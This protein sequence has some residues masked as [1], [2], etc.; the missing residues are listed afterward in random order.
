[1]LGACGKGR[2]VTAQALQHDPYLLLSTILLAGRS[3]DILHHPLSGG[4]RIFLF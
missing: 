4:F 1:M 3:A 2:G